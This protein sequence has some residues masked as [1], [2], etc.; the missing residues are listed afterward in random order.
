MC[1]TGCWS[2]FLDRCVIVW[3]IELAL[4]LAFDSMFGLADDWMFEL[5]LVIYMA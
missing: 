3:L 5:V 1:L 4:E 2:R